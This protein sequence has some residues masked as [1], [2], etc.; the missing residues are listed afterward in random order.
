MAKTMRTRIPIKVG[1]HVYPE[2]TEVEVKDVT[3]P[4]LKMATFSDGGVSILLAYLELEEM[5]LKPP[6]NPAEMVILD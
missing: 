4:A 5:P 3:N 2:G 1:V 6:F